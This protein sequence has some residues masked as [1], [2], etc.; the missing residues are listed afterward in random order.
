MLSGRLASAETV[1]PLKSFDERSKNAKNV[2]EGNVTRAAIAAGKDRR[3]FQLLL[4]RHG[5]ALPAIAATSRSSSLPLVP[6]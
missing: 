2:A 1:V 6:C 3:T 5:I 4:R